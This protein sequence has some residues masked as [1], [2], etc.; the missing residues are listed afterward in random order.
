GMKLMSE[1]LDT[2][3]VI[4]R[5]VADCA[6]LAQAVSGVE[7]GEP[8]RGTGWVPRIGVCRS[9]MWARCDADTEGLL[10]TAAAALA[11]QGAAVRDFELPAAFAPLE[12]AHTLVMNAESARS[13]GWEMTTARSQLSDGLREK[14]EWGLAQPAPALLDARAVFARLQA[15]VGAA[16]E[17]FDILITPSAPGVAP[18]G[19]AWTG[20]ASFNLLW[21][22]L[23]VPCV[24]V[25]A[26]TG[27][28]GM[29]L[30]LQIVAPRFED[31][32]A[33]AGA[34]WVQAALG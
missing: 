28:G 20:D 13:L 32:A 33:L 18:V 8:Q 11:R 3:G 9:P 29:P 12:D 24:T 27:A 1:S 2:I 21:T 23:H 22:A 7:L 15:G 19:L 4:A 14:M 26:G 17:E 31:R 6:L 16:M 30:G 25:P 34:A 10:E 5:S